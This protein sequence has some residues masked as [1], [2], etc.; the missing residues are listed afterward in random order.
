MEKDERV[1]ACFQQ[2]IAEITD[3]KITALKQELEHTKQR[4]E[5]ELQANAQAKAKQWYDQE[6]AE[7]HVQHAVEMSRLH[8]ETHHRLMKER[9]DMVNTLFDQVKERLCAF[10]DTKEYKDVLLE[11]LK[12]YLKEYKQVRIQI[13]AFDEALIK[14]ILTQLKSDIPYEIVSDITLGGFRLVLCDLGRILDETY[15]NALEDAKESFL[16]TSGLTIA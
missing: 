9:A 11:K 8:D 15:D 4:M 1:L 5:Q 13:G 14:E 16:R 7:L 10:R 12:R 6:A 2:E 3:A